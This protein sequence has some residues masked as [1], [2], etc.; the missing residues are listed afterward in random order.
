[1]E[2]EVVM[3]KYII[4]ALEEEIALIVIELIDDEPEVKDK[5]EES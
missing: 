5:E 3:V 4:I 1:M 2:V